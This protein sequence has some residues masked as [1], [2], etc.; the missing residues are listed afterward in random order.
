MRV[1]AAT[2]EELSYI[3]AATSCALTPG[4]R[5]IAAKDAAGAVRGMVAYDCW[6]ESA[7]CAHMAVDTPIVWRSLLPACFTYPFVECDRR[8]L[9]GVIPHHNRA[10]WTMAQ[11]LG[12]TVKHVVRDGWALGDDLLLLEL[13]R[14]D[15]RYLRRN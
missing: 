4:A 10:S 7:V 5:A 6:T 12:F 1:T 15:C 8:V 14:D 9:L 2:T 11:R 13:R 3:V